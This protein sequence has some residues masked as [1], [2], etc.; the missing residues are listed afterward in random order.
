[1]STPGNDVSVTAAQATTVSSLFLLG[2]LGIH[3]WSD[4]ANFVVTMYTLLLMADWWW[5]KFWR[6]LFERRGWLQ[7]KAAPQE[8]QEK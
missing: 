6:P 5:R 1:M 4:L 8:E 7:P 2:K 3:N